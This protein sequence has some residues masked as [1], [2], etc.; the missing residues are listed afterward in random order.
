MNGK[1]PEITSPTSGDGFKLRVAEKL[2]AKDK[3]LES[4]SALAHHFS[5]PKATLNSADAE[6]LGIKSGDRVKVSAGDRD[7]SVE[8][9]VEDSCN[10]GA[11]VVSNAGDEYRVLALI[12][13]HNATVQVSKE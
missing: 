1:T 4:E 7:L 6:K 11:V 5:E 3:I 12:Q 9:E 13:D 10:P 8:A 2:F